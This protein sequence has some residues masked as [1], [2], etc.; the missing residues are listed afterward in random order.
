L[1]RAWS[2]PAE[3]LVVT[4][5]CKTCRNVTPSNELTAYQARCENSAVGESRRAS[6]AILR[7]MSSHEK[8]NPNALSSKRNRKRHDENGF[9][10]L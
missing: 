2:A 9:I 5:M 10:V 6:K 3:T 7:F 1:I 4:K 8:I